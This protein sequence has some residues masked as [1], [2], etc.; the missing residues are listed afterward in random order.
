M[1][2]GEMQTE[3]RRKLHE[4]GV[5]FFSNQDVKDAINEGSDELA[6]AT[7]WHERQV[8]IPLLQGR[9]HYDLTTVI[10]EPFLTPLRCWNVTTSQW[11]TPVDPL[12]LDT[13][14]WVQ[15]ELIYGEPQKYMMRGNGWLGVFP[16]RSANG[17]GVRFIYTSIP[18]AMTDDDEEPEFPREFHPALTEFAI[19]DLLAQV[20][21]RK[22][23]LD[24]WASYVSYQEGL[25][26]YVNNRQS[27]AGIR[28]L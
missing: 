3:V 1:T 27:I 21:E 19:S 5:D 20:R 8:T 16:R 4:S 23:A 7:E 6:D 9:T 13:K 12:E 10:P 24:R 25:R 15:W 28:T 2:F 22:K 18:G 17:G 26:A 14:T 11:L